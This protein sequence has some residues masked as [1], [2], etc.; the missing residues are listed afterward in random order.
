M[1]GAEKGRRRRVLRPSGFVVFAGVVAIV[2][3]VWW[4]L[5]DRVVE[6]SVE[7]TGANLT[8]ARV[9]LDE[10]DVSP[11]DGLVRLSGLAVA[12]PD[13]PMKNL[14][15]AEEIV[16]EVMLVPLLEK[17][18]VLQQVT[19]RGVRFN[20]DREESGA[21]ENPDP[22]AGALWREVNA[23]ADALTV[24]ELS[25]ATLGRAVR[26][27]AIHADSLA[28][29]RFARGAVAAADSMAGDWR[30]RLTGLDPRP[31]IDS[32]TSVVERLEGFR[33]TP[34]NAL[35][36][37]GLIRDGR[38]SLDAITSL[39]DE[40]RALDEAVRTG[41]PTL[42]I[43]GDRLDE[44][45][46]ADMAYA[47]SLLDIPSLDAPTVSPS[48]FGGSAVAWMR[49]VLYWARA[50]ERFLPPGLDPRNRP[51]PARA[52]AE[53]TTYDFREGAEWPSFLL[54]EGEIDLEIGGDGGAAG[55]YSATLRNL[56]SS[57]ALLGEPMRLEL[58]R[59]AE[60]A[61]LSAVTLFAAIDHTGPTLRDSLQLQV[62][63]LELPNLE[64]SAFGGALAL[65]RGSTSLD[66][67]R[68]GENIDIQLGW[69]SDEVSWVGGGGAT[70]SVDVSAA[71]IGSAEWGRNLVRRTLTGLERVELNVGLSGSITSPSLSVESNLGEAVAASLRREVGREVEQTEAR[72]RAEVNALTQ[73]HIARAR[74]RVET[75]RS[76]VA[77]E[78]AN[79]RA[80][81]DELRA[82]LESRIQELIGER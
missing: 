28:S 32:I 73:P 63:G 51:G 37:P 58:G 9:D 19:I 11:A 15:E 2:V 1:S 30:S 18:V 29:V 38:A 7:T 6:H 74:E 33:L 14:F 36:V 34:L 31:R 5:A 55:A 80:E 64:L 72:V 68:I 26:T 17:K 75:V 21:L 46:T 43:D 50:A 47:R 24:P 23:W 39:Q 12:N 71:Q 16:G 82:R 25:L 22:E 49:P 78:V 3:G 66:V 45:R 81:V 13:R 70:E 42:A 10:A 20:T 4:L 48:L 62:D 61:A 8:G 59:T 44:L 54:Q 65:G 77:T 41:L 53:G 67:A 27:E 35:Q 76:G 60:A 69:V 52:R 57:P 79:R 40:V 56:T